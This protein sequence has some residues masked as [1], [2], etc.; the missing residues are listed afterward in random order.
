[1]RAL[2]SFPTLHQAQRFSFCIDWKSFAA[3]IHNDAPRG[4]YICAGQ[5]KTAFQFLGCTAFDFN[6][7][8][9]SARQCEDEVDLSTSA[10]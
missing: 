10:T 5:M 1:L 2:Q 8:Q 6:R 3:G 4:F 9:G 7:P